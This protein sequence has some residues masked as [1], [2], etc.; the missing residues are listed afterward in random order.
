MGTTAAAL[1]DGEDDMEEGAALAAADCALSVAVTLALLVALGAPGTVKVSMVEYVVPSIT[2]VSGMVS[3][4]F[5][6]WL[7]E[8]NEEMLIGADVGLAEAEEDEDD[9]DEEETAAFLS[10]LSALGAAVELEAAAVAVLAGIA[11]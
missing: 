9:D 8:E 10:P 2:P 11:D 6:A 4:A 7:I 1:E 5:V 3:T